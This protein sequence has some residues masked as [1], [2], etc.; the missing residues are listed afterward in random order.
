MMQQCDNLKDSLNLY[1][2]NIGSHSDFGSNSIFSDQWKTMSGSYWDIGMVGIMTNL[3]LTKNC[4]I[5]VSVTTFSSRR[6]GGGMTPKLWA[7]LDPA[8]WDAPFGIFESQIR[9]MVMELLTVDQNSDEQINTF[10][11]RT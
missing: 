11:N 10:P 9:Q 4:Q 8:R 3:E 1:N 5:I 7:P 2:I 6:G